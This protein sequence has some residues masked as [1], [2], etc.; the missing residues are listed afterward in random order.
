ML[1]KGLTAELGKKILILLLKKYAERP[2]N[3]ISDDIVEIVIE[4]LEGKV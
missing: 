4:A 1:L 3:K 2:D